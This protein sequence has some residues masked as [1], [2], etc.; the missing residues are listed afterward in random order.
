MQALIR[1]QQA[2]RDIRKNY[3]AVSSFFDKILEAYLR[4][5]YEDILSSS[6]SSGKKTGYH[7]VEDNFIN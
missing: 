4:T 3:Y 2:K 6:E 1:A 5:A 7:Y